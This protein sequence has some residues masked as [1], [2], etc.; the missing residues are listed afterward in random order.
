M[1]GPFERR[2]LAGLGAAAEIPGLPRHDGRQAGHARRLAGVG[3]RIDR[4]RRR[5]GQHQVDLV[6]VDQRLGELAGARRIGL[7][8]AIE[9]FDGVGLAADREARRERLAHE[10]EHVAVGLAEAGERAGARADEA[11]LERV[12][13]PAAKRARAA[14]RARGRPRPRRR[15]PRRDRRR[16]GAA[17]SSVCF[18]MLPPIASSPFAAPLSRFRAVASMNSASALRSDSGPGRFDRDPAQLGELVDRGACRRS[19]RSPRP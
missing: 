6:G 14:R 4:L 3:D 19:G 2:G 15:A 7:R 18:V 9:D 16:A 12:L 13:A 8:V 1:I 5:D 11:D 10:V 17:N